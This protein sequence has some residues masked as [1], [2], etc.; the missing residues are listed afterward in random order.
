MCLLPVLAACEFDGVTWYP[1]MAVLSLLHRLVSRVSPSMARPG[2]GS[3]MK[4]LKRIASAENSYQ[5]L[6]IHKCRTGIGAHQVFGT[7]SVGVILGTLP[8]PCRNCEFGVLVP[9]SQFFYFRFPSL[10]LPLV[11]KPQCLHAGY[12]TFL[13]LRSPL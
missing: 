10:R 4:I 13:S 5:Y 6:A 3:S 9:G 1:I 2:M 11:F 12:M 8:Q 7:S